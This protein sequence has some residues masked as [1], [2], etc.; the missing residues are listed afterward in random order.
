MAI[1][2]NL[3][4]FGII[5]GRLVMLWQFGIFSHVLVYYVKKNLATLQ[6]LTV[7][8]YGSDHRNVNRSQSYAFEIYNNSTGV[9]QG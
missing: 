9:V 2:Y 7:D 1:W 6:R 3:W 8:V 4:P 5:Y